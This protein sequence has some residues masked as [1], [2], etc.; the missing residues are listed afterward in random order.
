M[1]IERHFFQ[2]NSFFSGAGK[3]H[4]I[5]NF[6]DSTGYGLI[7]LQFKLLQTLTV[8]HF[9]HLETPCSKSS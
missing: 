5:R 2:N 4:G 8:G 1:G 9:L 6:K 3:A 7:S